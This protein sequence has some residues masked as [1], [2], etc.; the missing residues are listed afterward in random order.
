MDKPE[1]L[2]GINLNIHIIQYIHNLQSRFHALCLLSGVY[3][4]RYPGQHI[5]AKKITHPKKWVGYVCR[6][7]I[8]SY[9][10][11]AI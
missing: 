4:S 10:I 9:L 7:C 11:N 5:D 2:C 1:D 8:V 3:I 6:V